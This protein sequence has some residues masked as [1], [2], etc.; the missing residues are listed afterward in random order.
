MVFGNNP[1]FWFFPVGKPVGKGDQFNEYDVK[2]EN[3]WNQIYYKIYF[4]KIFIKMIKYEK[5]I[6]EFK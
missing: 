5:L 6:N 2:L 3:M 1:F 4:F